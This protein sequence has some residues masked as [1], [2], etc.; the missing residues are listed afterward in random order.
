MSQPY[1]QKFA[2]QDAYKCVVIASVQITKI[3]RKITNGCIVV[4]AVQQNQFSYRCAVIAAAKH[5]K[6]HKA[7]SLQVYRFL[8]LLNIQ[9]F[10]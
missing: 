9:Q 8:L 2:R 1:L 3:S 5:P 4:A 7:I 10:F 6:I